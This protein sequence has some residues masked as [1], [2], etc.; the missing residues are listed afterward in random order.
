[1]D[2]VYLHGQRGMV[3][4]FRHTLDSK[5]RKGRVLGKLV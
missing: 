2:S 3:V 1:M 4:L 5:R